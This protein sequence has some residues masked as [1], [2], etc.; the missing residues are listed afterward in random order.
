ML[1]RMSSRLRLLAAATLAAGACTKSTAPSTTPEPAASAAAQDDGWPAAFEHHE[2]LFA[3]H[4][5]AE[6]GRLW[7]ELPTPPKGSDIAGEYLYLEGLT[8]GLGSA[9][10]GFDRGSHNGARL[11]RFRRL[12]PNMVLEEVNLAHRASSSD[13]QELAAVRQSFPTSVLWSGPIVRETD[14]GNLLVDLSSLALRDGLDVSARMKQRG[15]G[16]FSLDPSRSGLLADSVHAFPDNLVFES[17][18]TFDVSDPSSE[19]ASALPDWDTMSL[20]THH[21]FVRLPDADYRPRAWHPASG[22][23]NTSYQDFARP[24]GEG[25]DTRWVARHRLKT[26]GD[27][28]VY[29]VDGGA[30]EPIRSALQEGANWWAEAFAEAG[31]PGGYRVEIL[32]E[33]AHPMDVRYN[34]VEWVHRESRGWSYGHGITDPRTGEIIKG[35][36]TLGSQRIRQDVLLFE[37][38]GGAAKTGTGTADD[39]IQLAL[40]RIRQLSAHEVGHTLGIRH[41]FAAS[42]FGRISV[43]D[44]P[45]PRIGVK[46]DSLDFSQAYDTGIGEWDKQVIRYLH[47]EFSPEREATGL[48]GILEDSHRRGWLFLPD[49]DA[50]R[51]ESSH[52]LA[53]IW[54][55]GDDSVAGLEH[56]LKVREVALLGFG[57]NHLRA[58]EDWNELERRLVLVYF[59]HRYQLDAAL[60]W[61]GGIWYDY[62]PRRADA[63][64]RLVEPARQIRALDTVMRV[65]D[66]ATL[67]IPEGILG[68]LPPRAR[69]E[70]FAR[71]TGPAFDALGAASTAAQA[72]V[73]GLLEP[74]RMARLVDFQRR[75]AKQ[76]GLERVLNALTDQVFATPREPARRAEIRREIQAVVVDEMIR[77]ASRPG[78]PTRV[79]ARL[80]GHLRTMATGVLRRGNDPS[81]RTHRRAL[82]ARVERFLDRPHANAPAE[83]SPPAPPPGAPIGMPAPY[84]ACSASH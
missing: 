13:P 56:A 36:V 67:D 6:Q 42:S 66:P 77:Q 71:R 83:P 19:V 37:S 28:V 18:M 54:D 76:P 84:G 80:E 1:A 39:P 58:G 63:P 21:A 69:G 74:T 64:V 46:G 2:G 3:T 17:L 61:I 60:K 29:Y 4:L 75:D 50:R 11:V 20:V 12:G 33:D 10:L 27:P 9:S 43:M 7:I 38:L 81:S 22:A 23:S 70:T 48:R 35:H 14:G 55:D 78:V 31:F 82:Q 68:Q 52:P 59:H 47:T 5:D 24:L 72:A 16:Q 49:A 26:G 41:N 25:L 30:P 34:V 51:P 73:R 44:Y 62:G 32:P 40:A 15:A 8:S 65:L 57:E 79:R 53:H 45:A